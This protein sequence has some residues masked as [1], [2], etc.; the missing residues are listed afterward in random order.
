MAN[1]RIQDL[2]AATAADVTLGSLFEMETEG[3]VSKKVT[4]QQMLA[5]LGITVDTLANLSDGGDNQLAFATNVRK[6][7]E[8]AGNG[9]GSLVMTVDQTGWSIV[10]DG[11]SAAT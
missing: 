8:G 11:S 10:S 4:L 5:H 3:G 7:G 6:T 1:V 2:P 9:S